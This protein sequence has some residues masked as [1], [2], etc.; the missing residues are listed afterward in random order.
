M[1]RF[2][3]E[4]RNVV[5]GDFHF[6]RD[7]GFDAGNAGHRRDVGGGHRRQNDGQSFRRFR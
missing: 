1:G 5:F 4:E 3:A 7:L 6:F 2:D